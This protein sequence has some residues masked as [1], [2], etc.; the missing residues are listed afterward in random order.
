MSQEKEETFGVMLAGGAF[1]E[2][3]L[4]KPEFKDYAEVW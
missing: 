1:G 4:I 3:V 2:E